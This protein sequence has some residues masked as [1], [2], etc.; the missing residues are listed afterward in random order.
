MRNSIDKLS[1]FLEKRSSRA[2]PRNK[3]KEPCGPIL[4]DFS[5][6]AIAWKDDSHKIFAD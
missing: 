1:N 3:T 6:E 2:N 5:P 4:E